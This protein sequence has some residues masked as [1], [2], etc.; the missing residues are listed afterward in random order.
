MEDGCVSSL[1]KWHRLLHDLSQLTEVC[2]VPCGCARDVRP[3]RIRQTCKD[4]SD[5]ETVIHKQTQGEG[6]RAAKIE[7]SRV[8]ME[9]GE[10]CKQGQ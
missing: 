6:Y 4:M 9:M 3:V 10:E 5:L 8:R 1:L 7:E 2:T